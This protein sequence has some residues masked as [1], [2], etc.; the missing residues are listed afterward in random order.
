MKR[1]ALAFL[2]TLPAIAQDPWSKG[3][4]AWEAANAAVAVADWGQTLSIQS[5]AGCWEQNPMI[6]RHPTRGHVNRY[7]AASIAL[8][9]GIVW[10]LPR[11]W[12]PTFQAF[13]L[14][15]EVGIVAHNAHLGLRVTF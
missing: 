12:R 2:L 7:F 9:A 4:C 3:D 11:K 8:H 15:W 13:T 1:V 10:M 5:K 14:G 6:G